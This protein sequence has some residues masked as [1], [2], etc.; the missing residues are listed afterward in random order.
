[1][2]NRLDGVKSGRKLTRE[3]QRKK[4][5]KESKKRREGRMR[6][7]KKSIVVMRQRRETGLRERDGEMDIQ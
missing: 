7:R 4:K 6:M 3:C 1:M 5:A 2:N